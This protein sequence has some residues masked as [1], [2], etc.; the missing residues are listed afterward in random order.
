MAL[1]GHRGRGWSWG[2]IDGM[3]KESSGIAEHPYNSMQGTVQLPTETTCWQEPKLWRKVAYEMPIQD[4]EYI[5]PGSSP[6]VAFSH[7][8]R[9]GIWFTKP[10]ERPQRVY[11]LWL[12]Q[13][14]S[15][16]MTHYGAPRN[17]TGTSNLLNSLT[18]PT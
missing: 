9:D 12:A 11:Q 7:L 4:P 2:Q 3:G 8:R 1:Q 18:T 16:C 14:T 13:R 10:C 15:C 5:T 6:S 17:S